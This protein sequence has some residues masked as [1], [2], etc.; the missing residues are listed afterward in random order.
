MMAACFD[1]QAW[2]ADAS[3][4]EDFA[5]PDEL[6]PADSATAFPVLLELDINA[7]PGLPGGPADWLRAMGV[8][9]PMVY[10]SS[11]R[12]CT[13]RLDIQQYDELI[14]CGLGGIVSRWELQAPVVPRR[15]QPEFGRGVGVGGSGRNV[16]D[17]ARAKAR[18]S[19]ACRLRAPAPPVGPAGVLELTSARDVI[20]VIDTCCPFAHEAL[21]APD[22]RPRVIRLWD[23]DD[24]APAFA[25]VPG[26]CKPAD[27]DRGVEVDRGGLAAWMGQFKSV[28]GQVDEAACYDA[29]GYTMID[30]GFGHGA[31]ILGLAAGPVPLSSRYPDE[32]ARFPPTWL[33][34]GDRASKAQLV[35]VQLPR[36]TVEDSSSASLGMNILDGLRYIMSC[37]GPQTERVVVNIS[38]GTSRN[39]HDGES[40]IERAMME[41]ANDFSV[42]KPRLQIVIA[43]GNAYAERRHARIRPRA[44]GT[45][46]EAWIRIPQDAE[47]PQFLNIRVPA[48]M[49]DVAFRVTPPGEASFIL[50][51]GERREWPT[52][53]RASCWLAMQEGLGRPLQG[54]IVW[55]P[56]SRTGPG[57]RPRGLAGDWRI[58]CLSSRPPTN[59]DETVHFW[60]SLNQQNNGTV[61]R[62]RQARFIDADA[63]Y[64]PHDN[65]RSLELEPALAPSVIRRNGSLSGLATVPSQP[66]VWV[67]G[68]H[69]MRR[70]RGQQI[71]A[72]YS[73]T[74][75]A[76]GNN[77]PRRKVDLLRPTD[78]CRTFAGVRAMGSFSGETTRVVGTSFAAPQWVRDLLDDDSLW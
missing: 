1:P 29:A 14:S 69:V 35:F 27:F 68:G 20:A 41:V 25:P 4:F 65:L 64:D 45:P 47:T 62:M 56:T 32:E 49:E 13:A 5:R 73:S 60:I 2:F 39:L 37:I 30:E 77:H 26:A 34:A 78:F 72:L 50:T 21:L 38:D 40:I 31:A 58:E 55:A 71:K 57:K 3:A 17:H 51:V 6:F 19:A 54:L 8:Q 22:G 43:A 66:G 33:Q 61:P 52:H 53:R 11:V 10:G 59:R 74:G 75:P 16:P 12:H 24:E 23:Q 76:A 48:G 63:T 42:G 18:M 46:K 15:P 28:S 7:R 44:V 36:A 67:V 70:V 9:V